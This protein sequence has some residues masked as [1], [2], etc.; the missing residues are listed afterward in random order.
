MKQADDSPDRRPPAES[1]TT[2]IDTSRGRQAETKTAG[3]I[4]Q[5]FNPF[6]I[7][8]LRGLAVVLP[9]LLT[10]IFFVWAWNA[11]DRA[12]LRP[13][14]SLTQH[15]VYWAIDQ[16]LTEAEVQKIVAE[17]P[18]SRSML[19]VVDGE[20]LFIDPNGTRFVRLQTNWIP[21]E[22][23]KKV[24]AN[25]GDSDLVTSSD[26][27]LRYVEIRYLKRHLL[28]PAPAGPLPG[29][30]VPG[31]KA[32]GGRDWQDLLPNRRGPDQ[33]FADHSQRVLVGQTGN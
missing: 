23:A 25:P 33:P 31:G 4:R 19:E 27:Y 8:T 9:P 32:P 17:S 22:I 1:L 10:I 3:W 18:N 20:R 11:I 24:R 21:A 26:Y 15:A 7:A 14:E 2:S 29:P 30:N 16:T 6:R 5:S 28:I 12:V 13:V